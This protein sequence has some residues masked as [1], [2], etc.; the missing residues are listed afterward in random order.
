MVK[1]SEYNDEIKLIIALANETLKRNGEYARVISK[2]REAKLYYGWI[3]SMYTIIRKNC[4]IEINTVIQF[5]SNES[6]ILA[7]VHIF[8][9]RFRGHK[10]LLPSL[11]CAVV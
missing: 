7:G 4:Q 10:V 8:F 3:F 9:R 6:V 2:Q 11:I 1:S 5:V